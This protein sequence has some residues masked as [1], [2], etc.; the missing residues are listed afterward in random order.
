MSEVEGSLTKVLDYSVHICTRNRADRLR[1]AMST[2]LQAMDE[3][4]SHGL[5][6]ELVIV[7]NGSED[8]TATVVQAAASRDA[9]IRCAF[10][11]RPGIGRARNRGLSESR[12]S[13]VLFTDDDIVVPSNWVSTMVS[14]LANGEVDAVA[15]GVVMADD[16][17]RGW[18]TPGLTARYYADVP[19][20]PATNP[21]LVGANMAFTREVADRFRFDVALGTPAYPGAED[22]LFYVQVLEAGCRIR[23][24][25]DATV[26]HHFDPVRLEIGRLESQAEGYGRCDAYFYH[27]WLHASFPFPRVRVWAHRAA[28]AVRSILVRGTR[29]DERLLALRREVA[30]HSEMARLRKIPRRYAYR[31]VEPAGERP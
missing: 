3:A 7:D 30:F 27:H 22:V 26:T 2:V 8:E 11:P 25:P 29:T 6:G 15:G 4:E 14:P 23:G 5:V 19:Y 18:M 16:L 31:G 13:A 24:V 12:G 21:G 20:P 28:H 9:R 17:R 10:E 1:R